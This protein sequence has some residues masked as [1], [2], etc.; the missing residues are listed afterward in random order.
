M[1]RLVT[2]RCFQEL[3]RYALLFLVRQLQGLPMDALPGEGEEEVIGKSSERY[4][5]VRRPRLAAGIL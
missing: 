4:L 1:I 5:V 2:Y 3:C